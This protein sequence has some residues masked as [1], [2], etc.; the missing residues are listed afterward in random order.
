MKPKYEKPVS[1]E[2]GISLPNAVGNCQSG[3]TATGGNASGE[4]CKPGGTNPSNCNNGN[5]AGGPNC[6]QGQI[7]TGN[8]SATGTSVT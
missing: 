5:V 4:P 3:T 6:V 1:R 7:A 8:C 2:L